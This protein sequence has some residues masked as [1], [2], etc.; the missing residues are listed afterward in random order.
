MTPS[1]WDERDT[2]HGLFKRWR[3]GDDGTTID[4]VAL[5]E[6]T[7]DD[8]AL[9]PSQPVVLRIGIAPD[10]RNVGGVNLFG[11]SFGNYPQDIVLWVDYE[12]ATPTQDR[13]EH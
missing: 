3:V 11:H 12:M 4:G 8:L 10:A 2:Q 1:W 9:H 7:L 13:E 5:S 6:V